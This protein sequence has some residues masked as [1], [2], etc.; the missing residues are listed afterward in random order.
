ME[1]ISEKKNFS[2]HKFVHN[3]TLRKMQYEI[4]PITYGLKRYLP[5]ISNANCTKLVNTPS[6]HLFQVIKK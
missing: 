6:I 4:Y 3:S 1:K 2:K 5:G